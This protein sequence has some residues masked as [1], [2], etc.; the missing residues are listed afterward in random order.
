MHVQGDRK[1][2]DQPVSSFRYLESLITYTTIRFSLYFQ[3][4]MAFLT[5]TSEDIQRSVDALREDVAQLKLGKVRA[6]KPTALDASEVLHRYQ[7]PLKEL[8]QVSLSL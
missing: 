5:K 4:Q 2:D 7:L 3:E 8:Q 6:N 1:N